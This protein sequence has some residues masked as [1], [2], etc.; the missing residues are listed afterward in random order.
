MSRSTRSAVGGLTATVVATALLTTAP[1]Y[2]DEP[3]PTPGAPATATGSSHV[4]TLITGDVVTVTDTGQ[5]PGTASVRRA[6]GNTGGIQIQSVGKDLHVVPD[7]ALPFLASGRLDAD[8]FNVTDLIE[9]GY[10]DASVTKIPL[11]VQYRAGLRSQPAT[12]KYADRGPA[13]ESIHGAAMA[14]SKSKAEKFWDGVTASQARSGPSGQFAAGIA[15]I[16]LDEKVEASLVESVEQIGAPEAWAQGRKGEGVTVA[17]LDT[18]IDETHPDFAGQIATTRSFVPGETVEDVNGHGTHVASTVAGTG[19]AAGGTEKGVAPE[20]DLAVGKVL[21]DSGSG[22]ASWIIEGMEWGAANADVVSMSLGSTEPSDGTDPMA[23]AVDELSESTGALFVIAAGN[24]GRVSGIGSPGAAESALTVG[25][26]DNQDERA[27][28]QDMGPRLGDA[29]V[30]PEIVAPGVDI[31]A[32]RAAKTSGTGSYKSISGTSM[33]TPH[34]AGAAALLVQEH[35]DWTAAQLKDA[36]VS[37]AKPLEGETAY[38]VGGGRLDVPAAVFGD[39]VATATRELG[40]YAWP[41]GDDAPATRTITYT[42]LGDTVVTLDLAAHVTDQDLAAAPEGLVTLSAAQVT[43]PAKGTAEVTVT[44]TPNLGAGGKNYSGTVTASLAGEQVAQTAVGLVKEEERYN[45]DVN[46]VDRSGDPA[47]GYVTLYRYGDQF[48]STLAI[49][50]A[51]GTV[52]SQRLLPGVYTVTSWLP[53]DGDEGVAL[54]GNPH[55]V[56]GGD[57]QLTLD[58]RDAN[59]LTARTPKESVDTYR[60]PGYFH[61]SG[62]G[63]QYASFVNQYD[64]PGNV[65]DVYAAPTG[66]VAGGEYEFLTRWRKTAPLLSMT[67]DGAPLHPL[68]HPTAKRWDGTAKLSAVHVGSGTPADYAGID[69]RGKAVL[70]TRDDTVD[71]ATRAQAAQDAGARM[72][73]LVN[74]RPGEVWEWAGGT[75]LPVVTLT[76]A[77][78]R[79]LIAALDRGRKVR[80]DVTGTEAPPYLYD[81][82]KAYGGAIPEDL[83]YAPALSD[84]ATVT[85]RFVG[86]KGT[87]AFDSR[88]DCRSWNWPPCLQVGEPVHLGT[89]RV[90]YVSTEKGTEWYTSAQH[91][92]GW[93]LRGNRLSYRP[94]ARVTA[95][96]FDPVARPR[97]GEGYWHPRRSGDFFAVNVPTTSSGSQ[98]YTGSMEDDS[99]V[100][101]TLLQNGEEVDTSPFQ[102]IQTTVPTTADW[103]DYRFEMETARSGET[104]T[105]ST[106][107]TTAWDFRARTGDTEGWTYLPL[108]QAD[109]LLDTDLQGAVKSG[110][111]AIGIEAFHLDDVEGA[112]KVDAATLKVSYDDGATWSPVKLKGSGGSWTGTLN[113]PKRADFASFRI[114]ATDDA[115]NGIDQEVIRAVIVR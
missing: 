36:L 39:I 100:Q 46:A 68:V 99:T 25:A 37:T 101:T 78:G 24:Y 9:Q 27:Y 43:V 103:A 93:G 69:A 23:L 19:A 80:I 60:R 114:T 75:D 22:A 15:K 94:G 50:P 110:R 7:E 17:V 4:V 3:A 106:R 87:L 63:G 66:Q 45:L 91:P 90:D 85:N 41:H 102:A 26:V 6:P 56:I 8:L 30:K 64:V 74:D 76:A 83:S 65:D 112:G 53:V 86:P 59:P 108:V 55:L 57:T 14:A 51:T 21:S 82:V 79:P 34:V 107:T 52:A 10:D 35:P 89:T 47:G 95:S 44:A 88:A 58:A 18:G 42:N 1:S 113:V 73:V 81:L 96:W 12:P 92:A 31:L 40:Y 11:I 67:V 38:Q 29:V 48:V 70:V 109:Y 72:L 54:V 16:H 49:D 84:L 61:D 13:L 20:A 105:T 71:P 97:V 32:A 77:E 104:W 28:F 2:A 62:I 5:G 98:G 111:R 33:A 115:G